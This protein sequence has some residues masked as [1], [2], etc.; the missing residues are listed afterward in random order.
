MAAESRQDQVLKKPIGPI[1]AIGLITAIGPI[2]HRHWRHRR[3]K[4]AARLRVGSG[5]RCVQKGPLTAISRI[6]CPACAGDDHSS[7]RPIP[8]TS[9]R[10]QPARD[11]QPLRPLFGLAPEGVYPAARIT[12]R[13]GGLLP[14]RFTLTPQA[15]LANGA[16]RFVFCGTFL[17]AASG[18]QYPPGPK[19]WRTSCPMESGLSSTMTG[20]IA[21]TVHCQRRNG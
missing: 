17:P 9:I 21:A 5:P 12:P 4:A 2:D 8:G 3:Q 13:R 15:V 6:L 10:P 7:K 19:A 16:R 1:K 20:V 11:G 14:H 18:P